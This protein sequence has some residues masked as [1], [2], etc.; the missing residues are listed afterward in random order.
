MSENQTM[1]K[2]IVPLLTIAIPA[3]NEEGVIGAFLGKLLAE[4]AHAG[5]YAIEVLVVNDG[6]ADK[7]AAKVLDM[8]QQD[9]RIRLLSFGKNLGH[10]RALIA[11]LEYARGVAVVT[12]DA[13]GQHPAAK[14]REMIEQ[15]LCN[16]SSH[17]IQG[18]RKGSQGNAAKNTFSRLFY[19][20]M[21]LLVPECSIAT[22]MSDFR[23]LDRVALD[24]IRRYPDR[25][26]NL[27]MLVATLPMPIMF[28][29]YEL[30]PRLGGGSK[31]TLAKMIHLAADGLFAYSNLPLRFSLLGS[32]ATGIISF[33]FLVYAL[34]MKW[35]GGTT[36]G[37]ASLMCIIIGLFSVVF[38][39]LAIISEY[40][41]RIYEDL[42]AKP[43]YWVDPA[44]SWRLKTEHE[45]VETMS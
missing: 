36:W 30:G 7:T 38:F 29:E 22:G 39:V 3:Y 28:S 43:L 44:N 41:A 26:R 21:R 42:R 35:R 6:S 23:L 13:D 9:S 15:W 37:W 17:V 1:R 18:I 5:E 27:R 45:S 24:L 4:F 40:V 12:M 25:H 32:G 19:R 34:A 31:Y 8:A 14:A 2:P 11:G 10:Q 33:G 20:L 16:P